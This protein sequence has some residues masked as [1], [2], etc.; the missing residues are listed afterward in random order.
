MIL[1]YVSITYVMSCT[2]VVLKP[3]GQG[4][5]APRHV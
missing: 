3:S 5:W 4:N 1:E 2:K